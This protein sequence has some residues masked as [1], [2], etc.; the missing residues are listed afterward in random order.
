MDEL[1]VESKFSKEETI[2]RLRVIFANGNEYAVELQT[3]N[4]EYYL[5]SAPGPNY[6]NLGAADPFFINF[7][8]KEPKVSKLEKST[9][10]LTPL[11]NALSL[12]IGLMFLLMLWIIII[13]VSIGEKR[14]LGKV[15]GAGL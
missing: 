6:P 4:E 11:S 8:I 5:T 1:I 3:K 2:R 10:I 14:L 7:R 13:S 12:A 9:L 15:Y